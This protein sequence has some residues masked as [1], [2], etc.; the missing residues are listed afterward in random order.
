MIDKFKTMKGEI[1]LFAVKD[2][3]WTSI[4]KQ[5]NMIVNSGAD[6]LAKALAGDLQVNAMYLCFENAAGA[7]D[8]TAAITN[9]A[10]YYAG[11]SADRSF[12]R[13]TALSDASYST[14][15]ATTYDNNKVTFTGVTDGTT[16][17]ESVPVQDG[18]SSFYHAALVAAPEASDQTEDIIFSC[19]DLTTAITKI[20]G[21]QIGIR[22]TVQFVT[23]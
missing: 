3:D 8:Y 14:S 2:G 10:A 12:V 23:P 6:I 21:A 9:D 20:A 13:V 19:S 5:D 15:D 4:H 18:T 17:F 16:F 22:W 1:E 7:T 11:A